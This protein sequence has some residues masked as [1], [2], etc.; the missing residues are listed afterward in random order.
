MGILASSWSWY[1]LI[2]VIFGCIGRSY[3]R[4]TRVLLSETEAAA[5]APAPA[6]AR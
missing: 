4:N 5:V 3:R 2:L 1:G 6:A